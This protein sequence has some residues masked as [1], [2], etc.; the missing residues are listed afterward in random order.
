MWHVA[1]TGN[2]LTDWPSWTRILRGA[3]SPC[4]M[5]IACRLFTADTTASHTSWDGD[6]RV[7]SGT[8]SALCVQTPHASPGWG[9][10]GKQALQSRDPSTDTEQGILSK[11]HRVHRA[12]NIDF[13]A[14]FDMMRAGCSTC[15]SCNIP[16]SSKVGTAALPVHIRMKLS[17]KNLAAFPMSKPHTG[18]EIKSNIE[19]SNILCNINARNAF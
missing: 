4:V 1:R 19:R 8:P 3:R 11:V 6:T 16:Y 12:P 7:D 13:D 5:F 15:S 2:N 9:I 14:H 17:L 18:A 10:G